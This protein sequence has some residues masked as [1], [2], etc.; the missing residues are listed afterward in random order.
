[1]ILLIFS[2]FINGCIENNKVKYIF[3]NATI[4]NIDIQSPESFPVE[5]N[6][7][8]N[9]YLPDACT[10]LDKI[11]TIR[12]KNVFFINIKTIKPIEA[13]CENQPYFFQ[14]VVPLKAQNLSPGIY[15]VIVNNIN[16]SFK[17]DANNNS[18]NLNE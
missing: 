6:V 1:M 4:E 2:I 18:V 16:G 13:I 5:I 17:I 7:I 11:E 14:E 8:V 10:E 12:E 9:G 3:G 15:K